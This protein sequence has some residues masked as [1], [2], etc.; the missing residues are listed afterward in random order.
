MVINSLKV[1][2]AGWMVARPANCQTSRSTSS[3]NSGSIDSRSVSACVRTLSLT[4]RPASIAFLNPALAR[5]SGKKKFDELLHKGISCASD[6]IASQGTAEVFI[7]YVGFLCLLCKDRTK[8]QP[9]EPD[10]RSRQ[11]GFEYPH[12]QDRRGPHQPGAHSL[13]DGDINSEFP[14]SICIVNEAVHEILRK[15]VA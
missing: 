1:N 5:A 2:L 11:K 9:I 7:G 15:I 6:G 10:R 13:H 8:R 3:L 14:R 12:R 4:L